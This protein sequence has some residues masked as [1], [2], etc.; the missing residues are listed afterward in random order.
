VLAVQV[1]AMGS[2]GEP[3]FFDLAKLGGPNLFRGSYEGRFRDRQRVAAQAEYRVPLWGPLGMTAF[4]SAAQVMRSWD[5]FRLPDL[6]FAGGVGGRFVLSRSDRVSL[7]IDLGFG[8]GE[9]GVYFA[10]GEAF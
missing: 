6:H 4:G 5:E 1:A 9:S 2:T 8:P 10:L 7:R 3:P